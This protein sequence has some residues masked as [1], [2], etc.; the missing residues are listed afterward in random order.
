MNKQLKYF[1][2]D[3]ICALY[4]IILFLVIGL[5]FSTWVCVFVFIA[6]ILQAIKGLRACYEW[7][8]EQKEN[9]KEDDK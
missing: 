5:N 1:Q 6:F 9:R 2:E 8:G 7:M 4:A 3:V